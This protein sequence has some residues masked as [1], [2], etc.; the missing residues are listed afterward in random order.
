[1]RIFIIELTP[2]EKK[3]VLPRILDSIDVLIKTCEE[4]IEIVKNERQKN[5]NNYTRTRTTRNEF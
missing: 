2:E 1:M 4:T 5:Y 3:E